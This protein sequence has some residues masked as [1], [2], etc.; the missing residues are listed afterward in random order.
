M[1]PET[2]VLGFQDPVTLVGKDQH[3]RVDAFALDGGEQLHTFTDRNTVVEFAVNDQ[4][5]CVEIVHELVR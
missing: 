4:Y 5:R 1:E 2:G 3:L